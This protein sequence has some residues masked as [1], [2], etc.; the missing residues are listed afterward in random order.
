MRD[1]EEVGALMQQ[2]GFRVLGQERRRT[3][4]APW[5]A[6]TMPA[7]RRSDRS[8]L[9]SY[10]PSAEWR[11]IHY[12]IRRNITCERCRQAFGYTFEV[13]EITRTHT[14]GGS[15][16]GALGRR[17][18]RELRRKIKCPTCGWVQREP[19]NAWRRK[20]WTDAV[21]GCVIV[22]LPIVAAIILAATGARLFGLAGLLIG[23]ALAVPLSIGLTWWELFRISGK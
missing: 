19:R 8:H 9:P 4:P 22:A 12:T 18:R 1:L 17:I 6:V 3:G 7:G 2:Y 11:E 20:A 16:D 15:N 10:D 23:L 14:Q 13:N 5:R 21:A